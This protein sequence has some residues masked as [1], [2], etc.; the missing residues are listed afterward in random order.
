MTTL[1]LIYSYIIGC[2]SA[3]SERRKKKYFICFKRCALSPPFLFLLPFAMYTHLC[4]CCWLSNLLS[5]CRPRPRSLLPEK[6][7]HAYSMCNSAGFTRQCPAAQQPSLFKNHMR[8]S[9]K[10]VS[11]IARVQRRRDSYASD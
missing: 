2:K 4:R 6:E 1:Y 10:E 11:R 5:L 3:E 9:E 8:I 7:R